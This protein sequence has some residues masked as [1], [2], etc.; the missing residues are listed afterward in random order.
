M[1]LPTDQSDSPWFRAP[2]RRERLI[3]AALFIGFG[4]FF[5]LLFIVQRGWWFRWVI[6]GLA[7]L[8]AWYGIRHALLSTARADERR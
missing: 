5:A 1:E 6:L 7:I 3:A 2:N 8:S 4:L